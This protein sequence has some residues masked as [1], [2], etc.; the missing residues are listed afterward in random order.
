MARKAKGLQQLCNESIEKSIP[1]SVL[2]RL[3]DRIKCRQNAIIGWVTEQVDVC[4]SAR[5]DLQRTQID[6]I[7]RDSTLATSSN[8]KPLDG[9]GQANVIRLKLV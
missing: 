5:C 4:G 2:I 1:N 8:P 9:L 6:Y 7:H 3:D